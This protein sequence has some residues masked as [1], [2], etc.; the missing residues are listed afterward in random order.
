M[1]AAAAERQDTGMTETIRVK[2]HGVDRPIERKRKQHAHGGVPLVPTRKCVP[3]DATVGWP[4]VDKMVQLYLLT[5]SRFRNRMT[6]FTQPPQV[7]VRH[8]VVAKRFS[9]DVVRSNYG[10]ASEART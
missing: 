7:R 6:V 10:V 1:I 5:S 9:G 8:I 2:V 3:Q 4:S